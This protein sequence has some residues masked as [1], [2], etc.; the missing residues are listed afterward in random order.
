MNQLSEAI[1]PENKLTI[2]PHMT[3]DLGEG[4]HARLKGSINQTTLPEVHEVLLFSLMQTPDG[5]APIIPSQQLD[6]N[7]MYDPIS[8]EGLIC[9]NGRCISNKR[10]MQVHDEKHIGL[11]SGNR[12]KAPPQSKKRILGKNQNGIPPN[13]YETLS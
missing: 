6:T 13:P 11:K 9:V 7:V 12:R 10:K 1:L 2:L 5:E 8:G 4:P 3:Y